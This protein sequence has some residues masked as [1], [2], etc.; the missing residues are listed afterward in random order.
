[1]KLIN[2]TN[3]TTK[4]LRDFVRFAKPSGVKNVDIAV[5]NTPDSYAWGRSYGNYVAVFVQKNPRYFPWY[6]EVHPRQKKKGYLG[7]KLL[8][9]REE[10]MIGILAHE[11][12]HEWQR[13]HKGHRTFGCRK[14]GTSE[15]DADAYAIK[16]IRKWRKSQRQPLINISSLFF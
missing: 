15:R 9:T 13:N 14:K 2:T 6:A 5:R 1:M 16:M 7:W 12:R 4:E 3:Y 11:L 10:A 8:L